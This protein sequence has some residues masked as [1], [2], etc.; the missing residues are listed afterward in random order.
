MFVQGLLEIKKVMFLAF[1]EYNQRT[2]DPN[3]ELVFSYIKTILRLL[4]IK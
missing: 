3:P 2:M 1:F 4:K